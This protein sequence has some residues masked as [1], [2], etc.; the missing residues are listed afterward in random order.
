MQD[1]ELHYDW[2]PICR[3]GM[4]VWIWDIRGV[5]LEI[6]VYEE[7]KKIMVDICCVQ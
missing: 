7:L 2:R 1:E 4:R 6:G 3:L 5:R